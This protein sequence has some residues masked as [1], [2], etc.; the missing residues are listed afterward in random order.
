MLDMSGSIAGLVGAEYNPREID[1][2][3]LEK[4]I[5][6]V[7]RFGVF[8]PIIVR[9][10][11]I[12][13]GHQ[14]TK[15]LRAAGIDTAPIYRLTGKTTTYDEVRFNQLHNGTD[16]D[17]DMPVTVGKVPLGYSTVSHKDIE[18]NFRTAGA[19]TR[20]DICDLITKYGPWGC[21]VV[22]ESGRV[23]HC[24]HYALA[25]KLCRVDCLVFGILDKD[26]E[27]LQ[28]FTKSKYGEFS[29]SNIKVDNFLQTFAQMFRLRGGKM[30]SKSQLYEGH[31]LPWLAKNKSARGVDFGSGQGDYARRCKALGY[32]IK[33]IEFF[34]RTKLRQAIDTRWVHAAI[35][36]VCNDL[37]EIGRFDFVVC[38]SV[39]NSVTSNEAHDAVL[40]VLNAMCKVGAKVFISG[41][42][43]E[44][45]EWQAK[46][47]RWTGKGRATEFLDKDGFT[48][49]YRKGGWFFQKFHHRHEFFA[50]LERHGFTVE[51]DTHS[52]TSWQAVCTKKSDLPSEKVDKS[53]AF[54]FDL[55]W[56][57]G[58]NV[59]KSEQFRE[60]LNAASNVVS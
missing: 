47:T 48:A 42:M 11:L 45:I 50:D 27:E 53:V 31:A 43:A 22:T 2:S 52:A 28:G 32:K 24:G 23:V 39:L 9:G 15:A 8:K 60:A 18:G 12:V 59:G 14:R 46:T 33:E 4:L 41:R 51:T 36:E 38:D 26:A 57:N 30:Q 49:L 29:Y 13:A 3:S 34:R 19:A 6:S 54:E 10:D 35:D 40:T 21:A 7:T 20:A 58:Q 16:L 44:R 55:D 37:S 5:A 1:P 56:P 17:G 25:S